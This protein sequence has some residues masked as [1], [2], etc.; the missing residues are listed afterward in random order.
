MA[1]QRLMST[2]GEIERI[3]PA[4]SYS[5]VGHGH[6]DGAREFSNR[7]HQ[8]FFHAVDLL[9]DRQIHQAD[10]RTMRQSMD[11]DQLAEILVFRDKHAPLLES[12]V[13]QPFVARFGIDGESGLNVMSLINQKSVERM[14]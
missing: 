7:I 10:D 12:Q 3:W 2:A 1:L 8:Q 5:P 14:R 9:I 13:H 4:N 11:K 6:D